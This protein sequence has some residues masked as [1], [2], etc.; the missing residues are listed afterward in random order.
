MGRWDVNHLKKKGISNTEITVMNRPE[1]VN[2]LK[3]KGISNPTDD[4]N[5]TKRM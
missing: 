1:D 4:T 5:N 3:K 2:H